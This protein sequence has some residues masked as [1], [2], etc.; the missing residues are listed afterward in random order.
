[1]ARRDY[2][3]RSGSRKK[4]QPKSKRPILIVAAL[5]VIAVFAGALF[6]L[7]EKAP[8][9]TVVEAVVAEKK[10]PKSV[11]PNRPEEVWSYIK[12][13]ETRTVPVDNNTASVDKNMQLTAEQKKILLEMER[14]QKQAEERR[15]AAE[16]VPQTSAQ[17]KP[18]EPEI[19][20]KTTAP[21][22]E[23]PK[24]VESVRVENKPESKAE[25]KK[26]EPAKKAEPAPNT[27][28][29]T[30]GGFLQLQSQRHSP[31]QC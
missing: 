13:L 21:A 12:A 9:P 15:K 16:N 7:K 26:P 19:S 24:V 27:T 31:D 5:A 17:S 18:S 23:Q 6:L 4:K 29:N 22:A 25:T 28:A 20:K 8:E 30:T 2:A 3:A 1:M 14:E 10:Q 11:L